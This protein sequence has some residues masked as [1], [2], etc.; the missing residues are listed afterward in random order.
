[1]KRWKKAFCVN[2]KQPR[3]SRG[4]CTNVRPNR[5][6]VKK[7]RRTRKGQCALASHSVQQGNITIINIY[8]SNNRASKYT[9]QKL[10]EL[11]EKQTV[12]Q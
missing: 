5:P 9:K 1:M 11:K 3:E 6:E 10:I 12:P 7:V 2:S 4:G 8:T